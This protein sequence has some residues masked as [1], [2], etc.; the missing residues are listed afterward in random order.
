LF[1]LCCSENRVVTQYDKDK[2]FLVA[3][4]NVHS[5]DYHTDEE[6]RRQITAKLSSVDSLSLPRR[7]DFVS[8]G[9][10]TLKQAKDWIEKEA[11]KEDVYGKV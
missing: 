11:L 7:F 3:I 5:G 2:V 1:E 6:T 9:I 8:L 10:A 4:R